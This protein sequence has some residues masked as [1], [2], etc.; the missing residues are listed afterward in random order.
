MKPDAPKPV[1][2][3]PHGAYCI[4]F[5]CK[6]LRKRQAKMAAKAAR[7]PVL[8]DAATVPKIAELR[9]RGFTLM[10]IAEAAEQSY[11][12]T[13]KASKPGRYVAAETAALIL[14]LEVTSEVF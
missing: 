7:R 3:Q 5:S 6:N 14:E 11:S 9:S 2:W 10:E 12:V 4:C 8:T 13:Q 1:A